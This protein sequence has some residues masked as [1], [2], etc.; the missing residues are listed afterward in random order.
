VA[1]CKYSALVT[2]ASLPRTFRADDVTTLA[3][4][5]TTTDACALAWRR[6][7]CDRTKFSI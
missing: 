3:L 7:T 2:W 6:D 5:E 1:L 4:D